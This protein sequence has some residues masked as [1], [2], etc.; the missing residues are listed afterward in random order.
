[1]TATITERI[2]S[3]MAIPSKTDIYFFSFRVASIGCQ[4]VSQFSTG[5]KVSGLDASLHPFFD[6][7]NVAIKAVKTNLP[8]IVSFFVK[9][10]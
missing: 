2:S 4:S 9:Y 6:L 10:A 7:Q 5:G 3:P 8:S 1:M